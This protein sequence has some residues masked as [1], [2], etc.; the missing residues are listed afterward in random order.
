MVPRRSVALHSALW[1]ALGGWIG[2]WMLFAL[3]IARVAFRVLPSPE[4]A[5][6]L[7]RPVLGVLHWYGVGAGLL[8]ATLARAIRRDRVLVALPLALAL[9]CLASQLGVTPQMES[10]HD[11]AFG[12][13]G[14]VQAAAEY[15]H[16]HGISM[17]IFCAVLLGAISLLVLH[18]RQENS[19][20][21]HSA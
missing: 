9:A 10:L 12:P 13:A 4:V 19:N 1:L 3:V 18:V 2:S 6:H 8:L 14:N 15:R 11:L 7:I 17:G 5:G 20:G 21:D 16:L